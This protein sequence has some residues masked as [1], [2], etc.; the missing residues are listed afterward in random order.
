L[1]DFPDSCPWSN[2]RWQRL[3]THH[4]LHLPEVKTPLARPSVMPAR[5]CLKAFWLAGGSDLPRIPAMEITTNRV[6]FSPELAELFG[7]LSIE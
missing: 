1:F 6:D 3:V 5:P 4:S 2:E 7:S